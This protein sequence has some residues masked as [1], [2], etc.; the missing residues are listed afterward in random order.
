MNLDI[1]YTP[2]TEAI[3]EAKRRSEDTELRN[4]AL[5]LLGERADQPDFFSDKNHIYFALFRNIFTPDQE[6]VILKEKAKESNARPLYLE[7]TT[8][9]FVTRNEDK[10]S[11]G[12]LYFS[13]GK[14]KNGETLLDSFKVIDFNKFDGEKFYKIDTT[15]GEN[16]IDFHHRILKYFYPEEIENI[17]DISEWLHKNG[18]VAENYYKKIFILLA[19]NTILFEKFYP[20]NKIEAPFLEKVIYP[21]FKYVESTLGVKPLI[22]PLIDKVDPSD[23]IGWWAYTGDKKDVI[24]KMAQNPPQNN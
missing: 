8:D 12:R 5:K 9:K 22:C 10:Y 17:E 20:H 4:K 23:D 3:T 6:F 15:T 11:L 16:I 1:I 24:L 7:Y 2:I 21:A 13:N 14:N 19:T 18:N